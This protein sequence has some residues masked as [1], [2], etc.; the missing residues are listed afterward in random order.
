LPVVVQIAHV[1]ALDQTVAVA[2]NVGTGVAQLSKIESSL[3]ET[4][5]VAVTVA[6]AAT[7][8]LIPGD[9]IN[10][11][12]DDSNYS[13]YTVAGAFGSVAATNSKIAADLGGAG[14][15]AS[16]LA[17]D[18]QESGTAGEV[19]TGLATGRGAQN[20]AAAAVAYNLA[21]GIIDLGYSSNTS[22]YVIALAQAVATAQPQ[23][24]ADIYGYIAEALDQ[25]PSW[26]AAD[27]N[28]TLFGSATGT[29]A[30]AKT[31]SLAAILEGISSGAYTADIAAAN[32]DLGAFAGGDGT[33]VT[34]D[35]TPI[36]NF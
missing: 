5:S 17:A 34:A 35:E 7:E 10:P 20:Q 19:A 28:T 12:V 22:K 8:F 36:V 13:Y 23:A 6:A 1:A 16:A 29:F 27:V 18:L 2:G 21:I 25:E 4:G 26:T 24:V 31:G 15:I 9:S 11:A 33:Y 30:T 3:T 32:G 14:G